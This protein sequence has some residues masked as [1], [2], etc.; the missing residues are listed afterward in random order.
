MLYSLNKFIY[1]KY[2]DDLKE[3]NTYY[4]NNTGA[5]AKIEELEEELT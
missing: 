2:E 1:C 5:M 3:A 4:G